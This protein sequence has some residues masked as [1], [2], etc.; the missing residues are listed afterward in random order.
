MYP[1]I[2]SVAQPVCQ[3]TD[4]QVDFKVVLFIVVSMI[5][6]VYVLYSS[7]AYASDVV[8]YCTSV[9]TQARWYFKKAIC[10][11]MAKEILLLFGMPHTQCEH[12]CACTRATAFCVCGVVFSSAC[13]M[14]MHTLPEDGALQYAEHCL[15]C[16][17]VP[18]G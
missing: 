8:L 6:V 4:Q 12:I 14:D 11:I 17:Y 13:T 15:F 3:G 9:Y 10:R 1:V 16:I 5:I 2:D 18:F 7:S